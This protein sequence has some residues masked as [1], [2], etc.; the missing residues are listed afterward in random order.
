MKR[1]TIHILLGVLL[2][3]VLV[4][5]AIGGAFYYYFMAP[6]FF[7]QQTAYV[8]I[9]RDD[10]ADS[11]YV[12]VQEVGNVKDFHGFKWMS[13]YRHYP[14]SIR[15]GRYEI[16]NNESVYQVFSRIW[17][18]YQTPMNVTI[19]SARTMK[20]LAGQVGRQL[21]ID[22]TEIATLMY[23]S[24]FQ[25]K[26]GYTKETMPALFIPDTYE[27]YWDITVDAFFERMQTE[28]KR[29][30]NNQRKAKAEEMG[31]SENEV[32][33]LASIVEEETN[34]NGEKPSVAGLYY[35]RLRIGMPLQ[36]DP[37]IKFALQ[38]FGIRRILNS[39]LNVESPYNTY[40][41]RGLPPGP[42]RI[43]S[44]VGLDAVLNYEHHNYLY[45]CAKEDF[46]GTH[47]FAATYGQHLRNAQRYWAALNKRK[48]S[49]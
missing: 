15:T 36:A 45:M 23:D 9:D 19:N 28:H 8:Y 46:S 39:D 3:I 34:N 32:A 47:N 16:R 33:T 13:D 44:V 29:F 35:N 26:M 49:R 41:H 4:V 31:L 21:M 18:G 7:P 1:R 17:R 14:E 27:M 12:K 40:L 6:Q 20:R 25:I 10:S 22:S 24:I 11:V 42:I 38:E 37:T 5:C 48:I 30:W 2:A 43:P